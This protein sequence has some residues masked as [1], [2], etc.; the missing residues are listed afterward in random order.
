MAAAQFH[1]YRQKFIDAAARADRNPTPAQV[2]A[3]VAK[4]G[5]VFC[6]GLEI[7]IEK[8]KGSTR[9][10]TSPS[11]KTWA[12]KVTCHYG[13]INRTTGDDGE[14]VDVFV[15]EHP[16]SQLV[17]L[18]Y[19]LDAEGNHDEVKTVIGCRN[20]TEAKETYLSNYPDSWGDER[21]GEVRA[22]T[23][24]QF[25]TWLATKCK[26][27]PKKV[28]TAS[29]EPFLALLAMGAPTVE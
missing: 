21:L 7:S 22:M 26:Y 20:V 13:Y 16:E 14:H 2:E 10:G 28:K 12:R 6:H 29:A 27:K 15:G 17:F 25:K 3:N 23:F 18:M 4:L 5:K 11:G 9:S 1:T 19:Q 24:D 8:P